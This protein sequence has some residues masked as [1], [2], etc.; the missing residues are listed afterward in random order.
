VND[1][2]SNARIAASALT[3]RTEAHPVPDIVHDIAVAAT[4]K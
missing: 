4:M 3:K 2:S 1:R